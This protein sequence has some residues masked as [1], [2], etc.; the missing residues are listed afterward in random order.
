MK[1][2]TKKKSNYFKCISIIDMN[3]IKGCVKFKSIN[4][5]CKVEYIIENLKDGKHGFHIHKLGDL[6]HGCDSA[7]AHFNP[8]GCVHGGPHS[9]I[10][11]AGDLGNVISKNGIAKGSVTVENLSCNPKS[12][13]SIVGRM[14]IIHKDPDDL[15]K[16]GDEESLKTGNAGKRIACSVI[17]LA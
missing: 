7:C 13:Y 6:S 4:K 1:N 12:K 8:D 10:R 17:G 2:C 9:N 3:G 5:K 16:G 11:H 15:G 14:I